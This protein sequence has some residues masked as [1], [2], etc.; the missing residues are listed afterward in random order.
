MTFD[1]TTGLIVLFVLVFLAAAAVYN[2]I[3]NNN[4]LRNHIKSSWGKVPDIKYKPGDMESIAKFYNN[5]SKKEKDRFYIDNITWNDLDMDKIFTRI[6]NTC[7]SPGEEFLY[8][9]LRTPNFTANE[10]NEKEKLMDFFDKNVTIREKIQF[11]LSKIGKSRNLNLSNYLLNKI[12][13]TPWKFAIYRL[14]SVLPII[15]LIILLM[16]FSTGITLLG[17]SFL[18]NIIVYNLAK[19]ELSIELESIG[20]IISLVNCAT[21]I[22]AIGNICGYEAKLADALKNVS[23]I[24]KLS[25]SVVQNSNDPFG[26]TVKIAF[27]VDVMNYVKLIKLV[28]RYQDDLLNV[29]MTLGLLDSMIS[30]VSYRKSI[31]YYCTPKFTQSKNDEEKFINFTD[32]FHPLIKDPVSNSLNTSGP[33]LI[34]GSNAS[35]KSTFLK[36]VAINAILAQTINTCLCRKYSSSLFK[37]YTSM[38]LKDSLDNNESYYIAEIKSLK[39]ILDSFNDDFPCLC[40]V[41]EVLRGTNTVERIAASTQVLGYMASSNSMCFVATHDIEL[42]HILE[43]IFNNFHFQEEI[44]GN[45]VT[46]DYKLYE[47][48]AY[49]RNAIKLLKLLGYDDSIVNEAENQASYFTNEGIWKKYN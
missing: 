5:L 1:I 32:I 15:C 25:Y 36:T 37:V 46:F 12:N 13:Y 2:N 30:I 20:R 39:R 17:L 35:G 18:T 42:T 43:N 49:S 23:K 31:S 40:I 26:E 28:D 27:L 14:L 38:A 9:L 6:N 11:L 8:Y 4:R 3:K 44:K 10:L 22:A 21:K 7:S 47:G 29:Y 24:G 48:R 41:D 16:N 33:V 34:T 19:A 45:E